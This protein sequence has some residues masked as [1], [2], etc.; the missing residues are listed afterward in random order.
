M[1]YFTLLLGLACFLSQGATWVLAQEAE[2][3]PMIEADQKPS[4]EQPGGEPQPSDQPKPEAAAPAPAK[5][6]VRLTYRDHAVNP[7]A[8]PPGIP[9]LED[10][11]APL[12]Q[13]LVQE[14]QPATLQAQLQCEDIQLQTKAEGEARHYTFSCSGKLELN[15]PGFNLTGEDVSYENGVMTIKQAKVQVG[16]TTL[17]AESLNLS[18]QI[19]G[20]GIGETIPTAPYNQPTFW[21]VQPVPDVNFRPFN[22]EPEPSDNFAPVRSDNPNPN[23]DSPVFNPVPV[24]PAPSERNA[25]LGGGS[26]APPQKAQPKQPKAPVRATDFTPSGRPSVLREI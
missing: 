16:G 3:F 11:D 7:L 12:V 6:P 26:N 15:M 10:A 2:P 23:P 1:H 18:L 21:H 8:F 20:V 19:T 9:V 5:I 25:P 17:T 14:L 13:D 22:P 4:P 24:R